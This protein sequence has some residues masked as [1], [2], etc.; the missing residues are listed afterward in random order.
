MYHT[1][2]AG[3]DPL[4][5]QVTPQ[6]LGQQLST[7]RRLRFRGVSIR[8]LLLSRNSR[9]R[10]VGLTFDDGYADFQT[11]A[12][13]MLAQFGFNATVFMVAGHIGGS[14]DW[15][16]PPR[17]PLMT[18]EQLR[19]VHAAGHEVGSHG[20]KHLRSDRLSA[21]ELDAELGQS[22]RQ[23]EAIVNAPVEGFCFPY[24]ALGPDAMAAAQHYYNYACAVTSPPN[25]DR[26]SMPRFFVGQAD[27]PIRLRA[28]LVLRPVREWLQRR[29]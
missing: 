13:P 3:P 12:A 7:L 26:W 4:S 8:E 5:I 11:T 20:L 24:G 9:D 21:S 22:R 6:R 29:P 18:A 25:P 27:T 2:S 23:L 1:I 28:K 10:L 19:W 15:D 16:E 17:R 14:N